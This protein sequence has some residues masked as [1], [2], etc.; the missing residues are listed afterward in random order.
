MDGFNIVPQVCHFLMLINIAWTF[1]VTF[2][3]QDYKNATIGIA[4]GLVFSVF[5]GL[6]QHY[7]ITHKK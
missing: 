4:L 1:V 3:T 5:I 6:Q 2:K 7:V